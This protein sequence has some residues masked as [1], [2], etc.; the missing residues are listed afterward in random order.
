MADFLVHVAAAYLPAR[1]LLRD[2][3]VRA[4]LYAGAILPDLLYKGLLYLFEAP[5]WLCEP[6]HSPLALLAIAYAAALLFEESFRAR[7]FGA[8]VAGSWLHVLLDM[9][10]D[11]MGRGV[12]PWAFPFSMDLLE[13]GAYGNEHT[14]HFIAP[15]LALLVLGELLGR[16]RESRR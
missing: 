2:A 3:R 9:G 11:Y 10:K 8:L 1:P 7:A 4:V 5:T 14:P 13:F 6:T 15:A 12:I 16:L